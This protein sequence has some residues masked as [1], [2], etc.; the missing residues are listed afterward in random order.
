MR[1]SFICT[2]FNEESSI[3]NFLHSILIQSKKP[4]E[5]IIV[6]GGSRDGT[7]KRIKEVSLKKKEYKGKFKVLIKPGNRSVGRNEAIRNASGDIIVCSD[8]GNVLDKDWTM[9][10]TEPFSDSSVAVVAGYYKGLAKNVFQKCVIPYALV[11]PDKVNPDNFLPAT[12]SV[13]FRKSIWK[14]IGGFD[15]RLSHN[16]DYAF[17]KA[18]Q[19][20][21]AKIIFKKDAIIYWTPRGTFKQ[22]FIMM[23]RFAYGDAQAKIWRPKV[24]LI[25][26]RYLI[27][28]LVLLA[29]V[30]LKSVLLFLVF[31]SLALL[32]LV[33]AILKNYKYVNEWQ[34]IFI[35][36]MLQLVADW[37]VLKGTIMGLFGRSIRYN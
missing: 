36:P 3:A 5:I 13:A 27:G 33:W 20:A 4:D 31:F 8:S 17:A 14:K 9:N 6:D 25:F 23:Y 10:I 34:A 35:L 30:I 26:A 7:M 28:L 19:K 16:E 29:A 32:Y 12:R 1:I 21:K 2:V 24:I 22:A 15:E 37:A 18:L 11:M